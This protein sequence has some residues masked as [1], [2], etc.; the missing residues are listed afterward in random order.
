MYILRKEVYAQKPDEWDTTVATRHGQK[1]MGV[2]GGLIEE[3][4]A[5]L[6]PKEFSDYV[7]LNLEVMEGQPV[8]RDTRVLTAL[9]ASMYEEGTSLAL[10]SKLYEPI[11]KIALWK[12]IEF[13]QWLDKATQSPPTKARTPVA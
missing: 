4:A 6:V 10:L 5:L 9:L 3:E 11:P 12:G 2:W 8:V 1:M 13:E 7:E